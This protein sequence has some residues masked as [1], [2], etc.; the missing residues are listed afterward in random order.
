MKVVSRPEAQQ[1][2]THCKPAR[3]VNLTLPNSPCMTDTSWSSSRSRSALQY[4][5]LAIACCLSGVSCA[6]GSV[7]WQRPGK[8]PEADL[9]YARSRAP[10]A[11]VEMTAYVLLAHLTSQPAPA[12]EEL[13]FASLIAKWISSQQNPNGGFSST[14]VSCF[15]LATSHMEVRRWDMPESQVG[16]QEVLSGR[17]ELEPCYR[18]CSTHHGCQVLKRL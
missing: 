12:Q 4:F 14:Q 7:H 9:P 15:S 10:S 17:W 13:S 1:S 16:A 8:E 6:D 11:E 2:H 3:C 5:M 18:S